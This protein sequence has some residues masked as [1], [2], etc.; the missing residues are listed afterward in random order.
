MSYNGIL[1][2]NKP[3][4]FTSF[5]VVA[6]CRGI[7]RERRIGH[8]GTLDPMATGVLPLFIGRATAAADRMTD[9]RKIYTAGFRLGIQTDTY[10][11][12]GQ[13]VAVKDASRVGFEDVKA[14]LPE[15][16]GAI[17]QRPPLY[18]AIKID[19]QKLYQIARKGKEV[20]PPLRP[21]QIDKLTLKEDGSD[22][23]LRVECRKGTY[24]R[25]LVHDI[26]QR[27]GTG[28]VM[29]S[30][31][32]EFSSG[33]SLEECVTLE[34]LQNGD[35]AEFLMATDRVF[36]DY[37]PIELTHSLEK[38]FMNGAAFFWKADDGFVRVYHQD[39]FLGLGRVSN[40]MLKAEKIFC[41]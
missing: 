24:I 36:M 9:T 30:L 20:V 40:Q 17:M 37:P 7:L 15:F 13:V 12:T 41:D 38:L 28:A 39:V 10:D 31:V 1:C 8:G 23:I 16:T 2:I 11:I 35:P 21:V 25:S 18:S 19:G 5:D 22:F 26:G 14:L 34:Q 32:R 4:G 29:T 6:K 33:F 3:E 27:L